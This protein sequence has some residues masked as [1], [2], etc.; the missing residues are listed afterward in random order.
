MQYVMVFDASN[1]PYSVYSRVLEGLVFVLISL[2]MAFRPEWFGRMALI[3]KPQRAYRWSAILF[4]VYWTGT[5]F[6]SIHRAYER[7][8]QALESHGC[9]TVEGRV[10]HFHPMPSGGHDK[11]HFDVNGVTFSYSDYIVTGG[12]NTAASHG[13][14]IRDDLPVKI[15]YRDGLILQ[16]AVAR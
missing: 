5:V 6:A 7:S 1:P 2:I 14:P 4:S 13:G 3:I 12:F 9:Q 16:L 15:C 10:E 11:E 8:R